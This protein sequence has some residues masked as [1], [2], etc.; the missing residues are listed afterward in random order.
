VARGGGGQKKGTEG[1]GLD[2][3]DLRHSKTGYNIM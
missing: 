1:R 3:P 2:Y